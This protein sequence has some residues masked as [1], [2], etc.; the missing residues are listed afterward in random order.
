MMLLFDGHSKNFHVVL[1]WA[2]ASAKG[3]MWSHTPLLWFT[4]DHRNAEQAEQ[5]S[6]EE[7][8]RCPRLRVFFFKLKNKERLRRT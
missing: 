3:L 7:R 4:D 1:Q 2:L 8:L 5:L 6:Y